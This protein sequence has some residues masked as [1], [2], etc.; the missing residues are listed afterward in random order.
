MELP[1]PDYQKKELNFV[2]LLN[3][4]RLGSLANTLDLIKKSEVSNMLIEIEFNMQ[5]M[6]EKLHQQ[7]ITQEKYN[8]IISELNLIREV[9]NSNLAKRVIRE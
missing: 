5:Q 7:I 9:F 6:R 1:N 3:E 4:Y 8:Q 2:W